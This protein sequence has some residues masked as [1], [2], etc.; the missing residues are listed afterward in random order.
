M[1]AAGAARAAAAGQGSAQTDRA[2]AAGDA[3]NAEAI[4]AATASAAGVSIG[5]TLVVASQGVGTIGTIAGFLGFALIGLGM[6]IQKNWNIVV[7][8]ILIITGL[9]GAIGTPIM[10][11][12]NSGS[13]L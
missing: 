6:I 9:L 13:S 7:A 12:D 5:A 10:G 3:A 8:I 1:A 4:G 2:V 11:Y